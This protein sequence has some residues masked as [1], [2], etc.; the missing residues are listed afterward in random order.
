MNFNIDH[1]S[2]LPLHFQV[3][4]LLRKLIELPNYKKGEFLPPEVELAKQ[5]GVSRNTIR[6]ATNKLEYEGLI[7]RKKGYGTKVAEKSLTTRLDSWHSF[8]Q[9]MNDKG[10]AFT[11]FL[12]KAEWI[13]CDKKISTFFNIP[14]KTKIVR[15]SRLRGDE[16]GPFVF[17]ESYFHPRIGISTNE[18]FSMPL[19]ELLEKKFNTTVTTSKEKIKARRASKITAERLKITVGEPIMLRERFVSGLGDKPVEYNIGFY[20]AE[21]FTYSIEIRR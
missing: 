2:K 21:K 1:S 18:D 4:E 11:N 9:E 8:T 6:Q 17:F 15:L 10:I 3:E 14:V 12:I 19:Y 13:E 5:L 20:I 7:I 16:N